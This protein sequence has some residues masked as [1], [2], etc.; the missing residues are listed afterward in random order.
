MTPMSEIARIDW[1]LSGMGEFVA[2]SLIVAVVPVLAE[3]VFGPR[4]V[5][6]FWARRR[7]GMRAWLIA[8]CRYI[9]NGEWGPD[10][11]DDAARPEWKRAIDYLASR[12]AIDVLHVLTRNEPPAA[13]QQW[14]GDGSV[15]Q[16]ERV[17]GNDVHLAIIRRGAT[18]DE[19][20]SLSQLI[21]TRDQW[22]KMIVHRGICFIGMRAAP[23]EFCASGERA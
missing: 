23:S 13:G 1:A 20:Y 3:V 8:R 9:V 21:L 2:I 22:A 12:V 10:D 18:F 11:H 14:M 15:I 6:A 16:I 5:R 4:R 19:L 7:A 17:E